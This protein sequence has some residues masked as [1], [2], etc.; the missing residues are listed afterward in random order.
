MLTFDF[1]AGSLLVAGWLLCAYVPW[2]VLSLATRGRAGMAMLPLSLLAGLAGALAVPLLGFEG[3]RGLAA[4]F[5]VATAAPALLLA[6]RHFAGLHPAEFPSGRDE[7][8]AA[9][10]NEEQT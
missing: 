10:R 1:I 4:S 3:G 5:L 6:V 2:F 9:T 8:P 7:T